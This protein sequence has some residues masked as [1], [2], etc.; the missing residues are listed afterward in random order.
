MEPHSSMKTG[1]FVT[2]LDGTLFTDEKTLSG[3]DWQTLTRLREKGVVTAIATGRS[4]FSFSRAMDQIRVE[5]KDLPVDYLIFSTGAGLMSLPDE[6]VIEKHSLQGSDVKRIC[7][8]FDEAGFDYMV[9]RAIPDT[10]YFLYKSHGRD[11]PDFRTRIRLYREFAAPLNSQAT[12]YE[13]A[14]EVLAVVPGKM[15]TLFLDR[16]RSDLSG[17][18]VIH[19]TSPL[20]HSSSW[21][22]VFDKQVSK[23][24]AAQRLTDRLRIR[25]ERVAAVGNDYNDQDLLA[26]AGSGFLTANGAGDLQSCFT[27]VGSNNESGVSQAAEQAGFLE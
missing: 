26:W 15:N 13:S 16:I 12:L 6:T 17:F 1:L 3:K 21:I 11:N 4:F 9:H 23:S 24:L 5:I 22:E 10:P 20:D 25:R 7:A 19:A 14:T 8:Y 2:D 18:S 27:I